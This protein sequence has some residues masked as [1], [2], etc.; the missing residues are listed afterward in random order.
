VSYAA[1]HGVSPSICK[2][3]IAEELPKPR[4]RMPD[5]WVTE[6]VFAMKPRNKRIVVQIAGWSF[7]LLGIVGLILPVLQG[8]LFIL[9]GVIIL[10]SQ[11][12]WA[13][14]LLAKLRKRFPK[15]GRLAD[16]AAAKATTWLKR[17]PHSKR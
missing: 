11:Y 3:E 9:V 14:V 13:R 8:L 2:F 1:R 6:N 4:C 12:A 17:I 16:E 10:S 7:I 15:V 5:T